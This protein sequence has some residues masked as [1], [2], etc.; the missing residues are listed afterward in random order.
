[1]WRGS[2]STPK[3]RRSDLIRPAS[4]RFPDCLSDRRVCSVGKGS[5]KAV[6]LTIRIPRDAEPGE[7]PADVAFA[8]GTASAA[9]PLVLTSRGT[10][11]LPRSV[12]RGRGEVPEVVECEFSTAG[13]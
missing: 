3:L 7:Y 1:V 2:A 5:L 12:L 9:L 6:Y 13:V 4:A 11:G 8:S 10:A